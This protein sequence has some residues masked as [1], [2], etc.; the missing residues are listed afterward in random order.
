MPSPLQEFLATATIKAAADLEAT[1]L[2]LPLD[3]RNWKPSE[4]S[5]CA[6]DQ[7]AECAIMNRST[8]AMV[9][10]SGFPADFAYIE[11]QQE[12]AELAEDWQTLQTL[13]HENT[14]KVVEVILAM[15]DDK[16]RSELESPWGAMPLT[17]ILSYPYW[18]MT[19]HTGQINYIASLITG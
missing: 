10:G 2:E 4:G 13:L 8:I 14:A 6:A 18:N 9:E 5:R 3:K 16:L 12:I 19:Y 17:E 1:F 15:P 7:I 11:Y